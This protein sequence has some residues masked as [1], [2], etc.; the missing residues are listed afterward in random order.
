MD[1]T[2]QHSSLHCRR[3][4]CCRSLYQQPN[5]EHTCLPT[6]YSFLSRISSLPCKILR[7]PPLWFSGTPQKKASHAATCWLQ[8]LPLFCL[9][10]WTAPS[11]RSHG[12]PPPWPLQVAALG[13]L[14]NQ[15]QMH[16]LPNLTF[17][18]P[19]PPPC[20]ILC[21]RPWRPC[22]MTLESLT[23]QLFLPPA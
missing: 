16:Y 4:C 3:L 18:W 2:M 10:L 21:L 17:S 22:L 1:D 20:A 15:P 13:D 19:L 14:G 12:G 23:N 7:L 6:V 9:P 11:V 8:V 5:A